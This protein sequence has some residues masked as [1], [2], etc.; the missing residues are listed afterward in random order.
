VRT[1]FDPNAFRAHVPTTKPPALSQKPGARRLKA[2]SQKPAAKLHPDIR[3]TLHRV[4]EAIREIGHAGGERQLHD[5]LLGKVL[6]QVFEVAVA[7]SGGC[8]RELV[9]VV[10][11]RAVFLVKEV[12]AAV[13]GEVVNLVRGYADPL[14]R[15]GMGRGSIH[16][17][18]DHG[19]L[20][21]G[22]FLVAL[23]ECAGPG[24]GPIQGQKGLEHFG[25]LGHDAEE[26]R[27]LAE[28]FGH[29][30]KNRLYIVGSF[31]SRYWFY[32]CHSFLVSLIVLDVL[33]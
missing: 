25:P 12:A 17:S 11:D 22:Q 19:G 15:S 27:H 10:D 3:L 8:A 14:R 23:V 28:V 31:V 20:Q 5:L 2:K 29:A 30:L 26:R 16:A 18:V 6:A 13:E 32:S 33:I 21:I 7:K 9:C 4:I 24:D 1:S